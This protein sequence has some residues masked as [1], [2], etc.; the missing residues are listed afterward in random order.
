VLRRRSPQSD[1]RGAVAVIVVVSLTVLLGFAGLAIDIGHGQ[2]VNAELHHGADSAALAGASGLLGTR[3]IDP[4]LT[5]RVRAQELA[6]QNEANG[7]SIDDL[8]LNV[9]NDPEG[10]IVTGEW[11]WDDRSFTP[12][13]EV[14]RANAVQVRTY[15]APARGTGVDTFFGHLFGVDE[16]DIEATAIAAL[17]G[18]ACVNAFPLALP[19][20]GVMDA[21]GDLICTEELIRFAN[22]SIDNG[23][24][25]SLNLGSANVNTF[26]DIIDNYDRGGGCTAGV[27]DQI[28]LNNGT[29]ITALRGSLNRLLANGPIVVYVPIISTGTGSCEVRFNQSFEVMGFAAFQLSAVGYGSDQYIEGRILCDEEAPQQS[30]GGF[31]GISAR[32]RLVR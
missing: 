23:G 29:P 13:T 10:D 2:V 8:D 7:T 31:Y 9:G 1:S 5:S 30:G 21:A 17:G 28:E 14:T 27:G 22:D 20:C 6:A 3:V 25:T 19:E 16:L 32:P 12:T 4:I 11:N 18:P 26:R 24:L 15:R